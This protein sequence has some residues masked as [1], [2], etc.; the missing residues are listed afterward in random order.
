MKQTS[1]AYAKRCEVLQNCASEIILNIPHIF[2][3]VIL[4]KK[5]DNTSHS[6]SSHLTVNLR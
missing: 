4:N 2:S 6:L 3:N 1:S 5:A